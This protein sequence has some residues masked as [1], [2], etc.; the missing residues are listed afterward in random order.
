MDKIPMT[1]HG[2]EALTAEFTDL[3]KVQ[4]PDVIQAIS[5]ARA[6]GDLSEN[7]EYHTAKDRQSFIEGRI[8]ELE[9]V[10]G[11]A[12]IIET[13]KFKGDTVVRFGAFVSVADEDTDEEST[14]QIVG[15]Y[16]GDLENKKISLSSP[17]ARALIGKSV[18]DSIS[19]NTPNGGKDYE[20]IEVEYK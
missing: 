5:T 17:M 12:D 1:K 11:L 16:E 4:R 10:L 9:S 3:K 14:Y 15:T 18:G 6:H 20:V 7:A 19:V 8:Q 13:A 2:H